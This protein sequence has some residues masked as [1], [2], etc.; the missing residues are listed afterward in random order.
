MYR[1]TLLTGLVAFSTVGAARAAGK[2]PLYSGL[3]TV[4]NAR[5]FTDLLSRRVDQV[6]GL[7]V[8]ITRN[9]E[10][11]F[12]GKRYLVSADPDYLGITKD[13]IE[14]VVKGRFKPQG[15]VYPVDGFF[16]VEPGGMHQGIVSFGLIRTAAPPPGQV[17]KIAL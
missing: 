4:A 17:E 6:V 11:E 15:R 12:A 5:H 8:R 16:K 7:S 10:A 13:D 14:I 2:T 3:V 9:S 1:R